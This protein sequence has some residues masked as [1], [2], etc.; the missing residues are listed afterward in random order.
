MRLRFLKPVL[1]LTIVL[2]ALLAYPLSVWLV[3]VRPAVIA[4]ALIAVANAVIGM[5][6]VELT[7]DKP[8]FVFMAAFFGGMG[9]RVFLILFVF[10]LLLTQGYHAMTLTFF[11]M[12]FYFAYMIIEIRFVVKVLSRFKGQKA[13][14]RFS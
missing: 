6:I 12:G 11:L 7:L 13:Q 5:V 10:A 14:R 8:N 2:A 4:A 3:D 9:L 1:V